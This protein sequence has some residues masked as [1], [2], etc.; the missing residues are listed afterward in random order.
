MHPA[1]GGPPV[2]VERLSLLTPSQG[3]HAAVITTSLYC[4]DNGEDL[5]NSLRKRLDVRVLP[6]RRPRVLDR[7]RGAVEVIDKA[8]QQVDLVHLHTLWHPLNTIARKA[9]Q[10]HGRKYALMPHGM[11]DPYSLRQKRWRKKFYLAAIERLNLQ[12]ASR[13]IFTTA[14]EQEAARQSLPWLASGEVIPLGADRPPCISRHACAAEFTSL[15]PRASNRR[16]LLFLGRLH[17]KKGLERLLKIL[18]EVT[19]KHPDALLVIAGGGEPG[20]CEHVKRLV[21]EAK[22][23]RQVLFTGMLTGETKFAAFAHAEVFLLPSSQENFAIAM[24]EAMHMALPVIISNKVNAWPFVQTS[25]AGFVVVQEPIELGFAKH[26]NEILSNPDMARR[27]GRNGQ[28]YAQEH[29]TWERVALDMVCL[30][31]KILAA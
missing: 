31:Q 28:K 18:P 14:R 24:A 23:E 3:W 26:I 8:V 19:C 16:C 7:P 20:Y 25:N 1:A 6:L 29:L 10:R 11:L 30:Y 13:L 9:C 12:A 27:L 17:Q 5:Q 2:V 15:F 4:E 22:L 21:R